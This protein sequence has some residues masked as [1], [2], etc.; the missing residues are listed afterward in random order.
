M[1]QNGKYNMDF[2]LTVYFLCVFLRLIRKRLVSVVSGCPFQVGVGNKWVSVL[3]GYPYWVSVRIEGVSIS[4]GCSY[5]V[6]VRI[7]L[8]SVKRDSSLFTLRNTKDSF[9]TNFRTLVR[10]SQNFA[11]KYI[12][13]EQANNWQK[14]WN[15][16]KKILPLIQLSFDK[17][18]FEV[19][20]TKFLLTFRYEQVCCMQMMEKI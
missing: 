7:K 14:I 10:I 12:R 11:A 19:F 1:M 9:T 2:W 4:S 3:S 17:G 6:D 20:V 16:I 5:Q 8:V 15:S 13:N 18:Q